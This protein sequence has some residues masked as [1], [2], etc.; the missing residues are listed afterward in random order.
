MADLDFITKALHRLLPVREVEVLALNE[1]LDLAIAGSL[2]D[3]NSITVILERIGANSK[4][5]SGPLSLLARELSLISD[6][7][8]QEWRGECERSGHVMDDAYLSWVHGF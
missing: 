2:R 3:L 7:L 8:E 4:E 1:N 6:G 5:L